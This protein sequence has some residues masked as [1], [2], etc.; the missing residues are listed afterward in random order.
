MNDPWLELNLGLCIHIA[1]SFLP[2][3]CHR[4]IIQHLKFS[5]T[6][7]LVRKD[8]LA[9]CACLAIFNMY[10]G[11]GILYVKVHDSLSIQIFLLTKPTLIS[12]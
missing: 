6:F 12:Y 5:I 4:K 7:I 3:Q 11:V 8:N 9:V 2:N 10:I 1:R